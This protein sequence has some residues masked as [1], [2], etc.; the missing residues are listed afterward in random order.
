MEWEV[1]EVESFTRRAKIERGRL[2]VLESWKER[3]V[4]V[5][6]IEN[7]RVGF[8]TSNSFSKDLIEKAR[9]IAKVSDERLER[10]PD[11]E[12][13]KVEGIYDKSIENLT[14]EDVKGFVEEMSIPH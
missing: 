12:Y 1:F 14:P 8:V 7:G 4:G 13:V 2:K 9:K 11:G 6:V 5:R 3:S 10:F